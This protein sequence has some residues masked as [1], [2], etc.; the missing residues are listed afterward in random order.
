MRIASSVTSLSWIPSEAV[1]GLSK[2]GFTLG[3]LHYDE[4]L[5][6]SF[7]GP[8][9]LEQWRL[10]D[11][12]RFGNRLTAWIEAVD[13]RVTNFG[14]GEDSGCLM[15]ATTV[16]AA[17]AAVTFAGFKLPPLRPEPEVHGSSVTF[18]QTVGGCTGIPAPRPVRHK[19]FVQYRAPTVW[20]TLA[21]TI[22]A[23]GRSEFAVEG[24]SAFP[25]HWI[26][27][28]DFELVAKS[29][30]AK[31]KKWFAHSFGDRTPWGDEDSPALMAEV[32]S[33][34]ERE[35]S[36]VIMRSGKPKFR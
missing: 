36:T 24:A 20:T 26:Y 3:A 2:L 18:R 12:F 25:R 1:K 14:F 15:G 17:P 29:G 32:E 31:Y 6:D 11:R 7:A 19:P 23:D 28:P 27:G 30:V 13:G 9:E 22:H 21:L 4:P 34:L 35:L 8:D 5:A 16:G 33:A 10:G